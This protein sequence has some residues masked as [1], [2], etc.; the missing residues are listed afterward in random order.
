MNA[1]QL[2]N[3]V[4]NQ[5][6]DIPQ[7][8][9]N[10][11]KDI[12]PK[13][14]NDLHLSNKIQIK[15]ENITS[16]TKETFSTPI[17]D[18]KADNL[19]NFRDPQK[20]NITTPKTPN[21][22]IKKWPEILTPQYNDK[23]DKPHV[24]DEDF[25]VQTNFANN[26]K[27]KGFVRQKTDT[28]VY[29]NNR[30]SDKSINDISRQS[31]QQQS[32][33]SSNEHRTNTSYDRRVSINFV[34]FRTNETTKSTSN[35]SRNNSGSVSR[36]KDLKSHLREFVNDV[37]E[38]LDKR[39]S[40]VMEKILEGNQLSKSFGYKDYGDDCD[41]ARI[42]DTI[43]DIECKSVYQNGLLGL[44]ND[45]SSDRNDVTMADIVSDGFSRENS[46]F[47]FNKNAKVQNTGFLTTQK[48]QYENILEMP[49]DGFDAQV[50]DQNTDYNSEQELV[51]EGI[52]LL[53][54]SLFIE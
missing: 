52:I 35:H 16:L 20:K 37:D 54:I 5:Q 10:Q 46:E 33:K 26:P 6:K 17:T 15:P 40:F 36:R 53:L 39:F 48:D 31:H 43:E 22:N 25:L 41:R 47:F 38:I 4:S 2:L 7:K 3:K 8:A 32:K 44:Y 50:S 34:Q 19:I 23:N 27:Y 1:I 42:L 28:N 21:E 24:S 13:A 29:K 12:P 30:Y 49:G 45:D 14:S 9:S 11:P 51:S 18:K